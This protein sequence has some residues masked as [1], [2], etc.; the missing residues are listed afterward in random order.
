MIKIIIP[1]TPVPKQ[2]ARFRITEKKGGKQFIQSY[3]TSD[4]KLQ[5]QKIQYLLKSQLPK[6]FEPFDCPLHVEVEYLFELP[7]S[8]TKAQKEIVEGDFILSTAWK[9]T[10]PDLTDNLNKGLFDAMDG[11]VYVND[12]RI[13]SMS[14]VKYYAKEAKTIVRISKL[15]E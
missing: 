8:A 6:G 7:K 9:H 14:A 3:Q 5:K 15:I 2:S 4:I 10:K 1:G 12:S 13:C 11:I